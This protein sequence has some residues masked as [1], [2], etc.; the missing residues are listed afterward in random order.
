M[1]KN[2]GVY[3]HISEMTVLPIVTIIAVNKDDI[4]L[5]DNSFEYDVIIKNTSFYRKS[6]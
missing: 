5:R 1:E 2:L 6:I 4:Y 3:D